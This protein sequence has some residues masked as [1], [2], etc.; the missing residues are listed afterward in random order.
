MI[1]CVSLCCSTPPPPPLPLSLSISSPSPYVC[2]LLVSPFVFVFRLIVLPFSYPFLHNIL[3]HNTSLTNSIL[4]SPLLRFMDTIVYGVAA[5]QGPRSYMEDAHCI[6]PDYGS[7]PNAPAEFCA[8]F[9]GVFDGHGGRAAAQFCAD[10]V[11][12][13]VLSAMK[14]CTSLEQSFIHGFLETENQFLEQAKAQGECSGSVGVCTI[15]RGRELYLCN[16]GD[17]RAVLCRGGTAVSLTKDHKPTVFEEKLRV[18]RDGGKIEYDLVNGEIAVTRSIGDIDPETGN[19]IRGLTAQP[20]VY[21]Y[22]ITEEDEFLVIACDGLWDVFKSQEAVTYARKSLEELNDVVKTAE[23]LVKEALRKQSLDNVTVAVIGFQKL[24]PID[25][26]DK[27][28]MSRPRRPSVVPYM[29][30]HSHPHGLGKS[31]GKGKG[32]GKGHGHHLQHPSLGSGSYHAPS[33]R[34][35]SLDFEH[36]E[37]SISLDGSSSRSSSGTYSLSS[38]SSSISSTATGTTAATEPTSENADDTPVQ[39]VRQRPRFRIS[40]DAKKKLASALNG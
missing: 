9:I 24:D 40:A 34:P 5:Q 3:L 8:S 38:L 35:S 30:A 27:I 32:K 17:C 26:T 23:D 12:H 14:L 20:D 15:I 19:K 6:I 36:K 21:C 11:H 33:T 2:L 16:L 37:P 1:S 31:K 4:Y 28:V 25:C 13:N 29:M 39:P 22:S 7:L 18:E 10:N